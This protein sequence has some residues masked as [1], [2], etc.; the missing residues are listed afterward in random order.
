M[1]LNIVICDDEILHRTILKE[2]LITILDEQLLEYNL[3]EYS[4]GEDLIINYNKTDLL[5]LDIQ[6]NELSGEDK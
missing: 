1:G 3:I 5:F 4:S 6:M 2:F